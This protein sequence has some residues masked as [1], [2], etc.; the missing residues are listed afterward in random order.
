MGRVRISAKRPQLSEAVLSAAKRIADARAATF[1]RAVGAMLRPDLYKLP[2]DKSAAEYRYLRL[3]KQVR[4][5]KALRSA[6]VAAEAKLLQPGTANIRDGIFPG[7]V[8]VSFAS[9]SSVEAQVTSLSKV[10]TRGPTVARLWPSAP[11][12]TPNADS[13]TSGPARTL[14]L[15]MK[16]LKCIAQTTKTIFELD[17]DSIDVSGL[18][19]DSG[20]NVERIA[21][22]FAGSD[23]RTGRERTYQSEGL[24]AVHD[25]HER[26]PWPQAFIAMVT[27]EERDDANPFAWARTVYEDVRDALDSKLGEEIR[28]ELSSLTEDTS[29]E[30]WAEVIRSI[31]DWINREIFPA[32]GNDVF[33]T[34]ALTVHIPDAAALAS[35]EPTVH[36]LEFSDHGGRYR[37]DVS[38]DWIRPVTIVPPPERRLERVRVTVT[39]GSDDLREHSNAEAFVKFRGGGESVVKLNHGH[40]WADHSVNGVT[41]DVTGSRRV[42]DIS[43]VGLRFFGAKRPGWIFDQTDDWNVNGVKFEYFGPDGH[44][45]LAQAA[46]GPLRRFEDGGEWVHEP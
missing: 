6:F 19:I 34:A 16:R 5:R 33:R 37:M 9:S 11:G 14:L 18:T 31:V 35:P 32:L 17:P 43:Q 8:G 46:G 28:A 40:R 45:V 30:S 27:L 26:G 38:I 42:S 25:V 1:Y 15:R 13:P 2:E 24:L 29:A 41:W 20:G 3:A 7:L 44:G 4:D 12:T 21:T 10:G 22:V 36:T 23:F 39:T